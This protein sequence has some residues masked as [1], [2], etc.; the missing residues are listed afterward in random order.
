MNIITTL[1]V[2]TTDPNTGHTYSKSVHLCL[3]V[4]GGEL[5]HFLDG[6]GEAHRHLRCALEQHVQEIRK[7]GELNDA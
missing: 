2:R 5:E 4:Y 1:S 6:L 3:E 7:G